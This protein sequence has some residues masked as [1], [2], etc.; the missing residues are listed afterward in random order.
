MLRKIVRIDEEKCTGCG[1]CVGACVEGAIEIVD[2]KARLVGETYCDGLGACLGECPE[3]AITIEERES[4]P[5]DAEAVAK[6]QASAAK[7]SEQQPHTCPGSMAR[8]IRRRPSPGAAAP[9]P[10]AA[11]ELTHWP[12]QLALV[13]PD[14]PYFRDADVLL[15]ADCVPFAL[16]DFHARLL[17]GHAVVIGCPKLDNPDFYIEKLT[18]ILATAGV[19]S[20]TVVHMEVPCCFG[21]T[22]IA[23]SA[24]A[25]CGCESP[26]RDVTVGIDGEVRDES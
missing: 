2:G 11:S 6:R 8:E 21:L 15:V 9:A 24:M 12:V 22:H 26:M 7:G 17:H 18:R 10:G 3:G 25:A 1:E 19:K 13:P 4:E 14:A 23:R 20:L 5:F 16:G